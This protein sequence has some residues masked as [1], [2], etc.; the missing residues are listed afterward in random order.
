[1]N[2]SS[3]VVFEICVLPDPI[4]LKAHIFIDKFPLPRPLFVGRLLALHSDFGEILRMVDPKS[5]ITDAELSKGINALSRSGNI[6]LVTY[7]DPFC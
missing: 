3:P 6:V 7:L 4:I 1:M 5:V 2:W